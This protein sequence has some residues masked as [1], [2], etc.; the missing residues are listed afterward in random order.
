[1]AWSERFKVFAS[2]RRSDDV[3]EPSVHR[4]GEADQEGVRPEE[5][6]LLELV[7]ILTLSVQADGE[8]LAHGR[9]EEVLERVAEHRALLHDLEAVLL[10]HREEI[11]LWPEAKK[12][13]IEGAFSRLSSQAEA[14]GR[15]LGV[16]HSASQ[17]ICAHMLQA[18]ERQ[19]SDGTYRRSG[20]K[21]KS[22]QLSLSQ[23]SA[24][25]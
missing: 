21:Q 8:A 24:K 15:H 11:R 13:S 4:A 7:E 14:T 10:E 9:I 6:R 22:K 5:K 2:T 16:L 18:A 19:L 1:M 20:E 12:H 17:T 3:V 25:L 23:F